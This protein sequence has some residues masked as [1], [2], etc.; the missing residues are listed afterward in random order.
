MGDAMPA[1]KYSLAPSRKNLRTTA[2]LTICLLAVSGCASIIN[3]H[4]DIAQ[5]NPTPVGTVSFDSAEKYANNAKAKYRAALGEHAQF[6]RL[7]GASLIPLGAATL[8]LGI[9]GVSTEA[10]TALGLAGA[11]GYGEGVWLESTPTQRAYVAGYNTTVCAVEAMIPLKFDEKNE[12]LKEFRANLT[13]GEDGKTEID[14]KIEAVDSVTREV[15]RLKASETDANMKQIADD[16]IEAAKA[17]IQSAA[18]A[19]SNAVS[20]L[21][22]IDHAGSNL[23]SAT[24]KIAGQVDEAILTSQPDLQALSAIIGGLGQSYSKFTAVPA[25]L[26]PPTKAVAAPGQVPAGASY[27]TRRTVREDL[28]TALAQLETSTAALATGTR[29]LSDFVNAAVA[30][31]PLETLAKCGVDP[32]KVMTDIVIDPAGPF[33]VEPGKDSSQGFTIKGGRQPYYA[34]LENDTV[35]GLTVTQPDVFGPGFVVKA[36]NLAEGE[37]TVLVGDGAGH[38]AFLKVISAKPKKSGDQSGS[39]TGTDQAA[40]IMNIQERLCVKQDGVVGPETAAAIKQYQTETGKEADGK[41]TPALQDEILA[42]PTEKY[43]ARC[44]KLARVGAPANSFAAEAEKIKTGLTFSV[45]GTNNVGGTNFKVAKAELNPA[46]DKVLVTLDPA[47][48]TVSQPVGEALVK[49]ALIKKSGANIQPGQ[50]DLTNY[51]VK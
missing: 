19:R 16:D 2:A 48:K 12:Q 1:W 11:A 45:G 33:N 17:A 39:D 4:V 38:S 18:T 30:K 46:G 9:T 14:R 7:L 32:S 27:E 31:K 10:V 15:K 43:K 8:G 47:D 36:T 37:Y 3:P 28:Q 5:D 23:V 6:N 26:Q 29:E 21:G 34:K 24:E 49:E 20:L 42:I 35:K 40:T 25:S 41:L 44:A 50:I 51:E 13:K 22:E